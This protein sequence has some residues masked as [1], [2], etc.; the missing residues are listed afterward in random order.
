MLHSKMKKISAIILLITLFLTFI[1]L[2][3]TSHIYA[4]GTG[5]NSNIEMT[6]PVNEV[7][8]EQTTVTEEFVIPHSIVEIP[9]DEMFTDESYVSVEG[10]TGLTRKTF[11]VRYENGTQVSKV[12]IHEEIITKPVD[13][14]KYVG[15]QVRKIKT[16][17]GTMTEKPAK[18]GRYIDMTATAYDLSYESCGKRPGDRGYGITASGMK[19]RVGVVAVDRRVIPLGTRLYIEAVD[20]SWVYGEAIAGDTGGAI[21][22]NRI[23]LF[24]NTKAECMQFG[25]KA[26][27]VYILD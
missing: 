12:L 24:F 23:D 11:E 7:K 22:G 9:T 6:Q 1:A 21:K 19:A 18:L 4:E 26:A 27:R 16:I 14:I 13:T 17:A 8:T 2:S 5:S 10:T 3:V 20:G 15:T 25:K